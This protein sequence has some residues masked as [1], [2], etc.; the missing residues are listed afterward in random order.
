MK[1]KIHIPMLDLEDKNI[2]KASETTTKNMNVSIDQPLTFEKPYKQIATTRG[3]KP[4]R[5]KPMVEG[6]KTK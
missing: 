6:S 2:E 5:P 1:D 4:Q 3:P